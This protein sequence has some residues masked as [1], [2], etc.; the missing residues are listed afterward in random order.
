[1]KIEELSTEGL[2]S[3]YEAVRI[4]L[5]EDN[6]LPKGNKKFGTR[7][8]LDWRQWSDGIAQELT[9]RGETVVTLPW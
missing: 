1:M 4:A 7:E 6:S 9:R 8:H 3:L 5:K 2:V